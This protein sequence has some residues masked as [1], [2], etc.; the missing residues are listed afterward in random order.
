MIRWNVAHFLAG[1]LALTIATTSLAN[2]VMSHETNG[3]RTL[4]PYCHHW[5]AYCP[6]FSAKTDWEH[7]LDEAEFSEFFT[8]ERQIVHNPNEEAE[9]QG[10]EE[11][12]KYAVVQSIPTEDFGGGDWVWGVGPTFQFPTASFDES[13]HQQHA[14][15]HRG[16]GSG[17]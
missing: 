16:L 8:A 13:R 17:Q 5:F 2:D 15:H 10:S 12:G 3:G 6:S 11:S 9:H 7:R 14:N 4:D 1:V